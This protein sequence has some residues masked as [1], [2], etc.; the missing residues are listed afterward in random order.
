VAALERFL[1][2]VTG[3]GHWRGEGMALVV[4]IR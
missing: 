4:A 2:V 1:A 3:V